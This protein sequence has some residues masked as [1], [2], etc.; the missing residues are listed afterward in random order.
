MTAAPWAARGLSAT[1]QAAAALRG[2]DPSEQNRPSGVPVSPR[3]CSLAGGC[4]SPG[5]VRGPLTPEAPPG[6]RG[7]W[8]F[9]AQPWLLWSWK[10]SPPHLEA[11]LFPFDL[12]FYS[13]FVSIGMWF[14]L[15]LDIKCYCYTVI[16]CSSVSE[17]S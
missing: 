3:S 17:D 6:G 10:L 1:T 4:R 15:S 2:P 16:F 12:N 13:H 9:L 7:V 8:P 5:T 11:S 14:P